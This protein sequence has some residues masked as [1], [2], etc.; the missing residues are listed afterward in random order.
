MENFL[1]FIAAIAGSLVGSII[2]GI[3]FSKIGDNCNER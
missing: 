2:V 3:I 1:I